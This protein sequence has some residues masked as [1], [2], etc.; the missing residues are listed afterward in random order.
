MTQS[1]Y[2]CDRRSFLRTTGAALAAGATVPMFA[3]ATSAEQSTTGST[4]PPRFCKF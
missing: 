2:G 4:P 3:P 1:A